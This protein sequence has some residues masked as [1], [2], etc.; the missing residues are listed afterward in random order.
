MSAES[1]SEVGS[2]LGMDSLQSLPVQNDISIFWDII[3]APWG[4]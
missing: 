3:L 1:R 2:H 4:G